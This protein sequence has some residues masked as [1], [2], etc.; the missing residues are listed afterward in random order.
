MNLDH[1][2]MVLLTCVLVVAGF[3]KGTIGFGLPLVALSVLTQFLPKEWALAVMVLPVVFSNLFIGFDKHLFVPSLRRFWP[4]ILAIGA[5]MAAGVLGLSG[6]PQDA[7]LLVVGLVVIV[8]ALL[9]QFRLVLP[10]PAAHERA[11]GLG[12]GLLGGLLGGIST[13]FGPPLVMYFTALRLPKDQFVAAIG[14]VWSFA[15]VF[16]I[17]AFSSAAILAGDRITWSVAA[18]IP[19]GLGLWAGIRLRNRIPQEPFRRLVAVALLILGANLI[20]RGIS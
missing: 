11:V 12:A 15:S 20:R 17:V 5:G 6:L 10:V 3:V 14:V 4:T 7:F 8:F 1:P 18:C 2:T 19:V 9:E 16:L 13:A